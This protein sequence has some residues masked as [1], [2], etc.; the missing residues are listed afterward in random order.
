MIINGKK[1]K[2]PTVSKTSRLSHYIGKTVRSRRRSKG[3]TIEKL[4]EESELNDKYLGE[5]ERGEVNISIETLFKI[6]NGLSLKD[7][8]DL[9]VEATREVYSSMSKREE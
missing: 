5:I 4:A 6:A 1:E 7:P 8:S 9:L 3:I 2:V